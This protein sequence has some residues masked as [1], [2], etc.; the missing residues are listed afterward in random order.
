[1]LKPDS[2]TP[3]RALPPEMEGEAVFQK[4]LELF[5]RSS[6]DKRIEL[7]KI[8]EVIADLRHRRRFLDVGAGSGDLTIPLAQTFHET[9][10]VE[11]NTAQIEF[12]RRRYPHFRLHNVTWSDADLGADRFDFILC[13]HVLYYLDKA[14]WMPAIDKMGAHLEQDGRLVIVLQSPI[15][16]LADFYNHFAHFDVDIL[17]LWRELIHRFGDKAVQVRYFIN[18]I[19]TD[20]LDDMV[21]IGLFLLID[22]RFR[23]RV[24]EIRDYFATHHR[25]GEGYR[26]KQDEILLSVRHLAQ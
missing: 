10:I 13:S 23:A 21:E 11:P 25:Q 7:V 3:G 26:L 12:L 2:A 24:D 22:R 6:T 5:I 20:S 15:G 8:G 4:Q 9:T 14:D 17:G 16:E 18:E 1:M 19:W